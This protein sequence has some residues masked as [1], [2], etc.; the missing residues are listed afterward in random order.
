MNILLT[1]GA[2]YIG[3][4]VAKTATHAGHTVV[5]VDNLTFG[6][7]WA[8]RW[9]PLERGDLADHDWLRGV[10]ARHRFDAVMHF[11]A[12]A[13]V[14]E[15][16][17]DP[18]KYFWNNAVG[19]LVLLDVMR[20]AG[21]S[22]IV[23][24]STC[25]TYGN[26]VRVPIDEAHPQVPVNPYGESKL[27]VERVLRSYGEAYGLRWIALRYFNAAGADPSAE[28]GEDH[29]PETHLI[30]LVIQTALGFKPF[31]E[32]YGTDYPTPDGTPIRDYIHV[33][34]LAAAHLQGLMHLTNGGES[35]ALNLGTGKGHSVREVIAAVTSISGTAVPVREAPRRVGDPPILVADASAARQRLGWQPAYSNL[36]TIVAH[37]WE[38][39]KRQLPTPNVSD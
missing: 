15:S 29:D 32:V 22:T 4:H 10:F 6:H 5:V 30:P 19:S 23:F 38:W 13:L 27:F 34:D 39:H 31:V 7:E 24:S 26:P 37:A 35:I 1:G 12:N 2:G 28:L 16:T 18:Q 36:Q 20:E 8:V 33:M 3:S 21:V 25:A 17:S 11:A 9:G 14:G